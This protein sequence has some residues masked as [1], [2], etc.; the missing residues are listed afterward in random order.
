MI[1]GF[2]L[3]VRIFIFPWDLYLRA[4][5]DFQLAPASTAA[6]QAPSFEHH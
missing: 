2:C 6:S 1:V 5:V 4:P 3:L